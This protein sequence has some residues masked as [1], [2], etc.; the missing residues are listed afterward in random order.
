MLGGY[1]EFFMIPAVA[2]MY[3]C[4]RSE[5]DDLIQSKVSESLKRPTFKMVG[6]YYFY[7]SFYFL[8]HYYSYLL[9]FILSSM[10]I[11]IIYFLLITI[12]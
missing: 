1:L 4:L 5:L 12:V 3:E 10:I 9:V 7:D 11:I 8:N 2:D 6:F